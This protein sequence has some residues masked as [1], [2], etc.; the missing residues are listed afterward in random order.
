[1]NI[2]FYK[3]SGGGSGPKIMAACLRVNNWDDYS[4]KTLFYLT[5]YDEQGIEH[6]IGS[7]K[8]G[9]VNQQH[10]WT[11][12]S[13]PPFFDFLPEKYFSLGQDVSYYESLQKNLTAELFEQVLIG[14]RD[15]AYDTNIF[16]IA[17]EER[18]FKDSLTRGVSVSAI[19]NQYRRVI[20]G[21]AVLTPFDFSY[22]RAATD[23]IGGAD[24]SFKVI[25]G[26]KPPTNMHVLIG[27]NG[28]GK[29]TLLNGMIRSIVQGAD[30]QSG[31]G[32]FTDN[33]PWSGGGPIGSDYFSSV[34][35]V[36]FSAFDPFIPPPDRIN[37]AEGTCYYYIGLK[38]SASIKPDGSY[39]LKTMVELSREF[40]KSLSVCFSLEKKR[41]QWVAAIKRLESDSNFKSMDLPAL[42]R[43]PAFSAF[44]RAE[45]LFNKMSSGHAIVLLTITRLVE[46]VEEKTLVLLDEPE[47]HLHPPLLSA[48]TRAMSDL[49]TDRNG[50]AIIAT[51]SPVV[52]QEVPS[53]CVWKVRRSNLMTYAERPESETFAENVGVLTREVFGL[54]V[55]K[56]GFYDLLAQSIAEGKGYQEVF[57]EYGGQLGFE[58]QALLRALIKAQE[59]DV[60]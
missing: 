22:M 59:D 44:N 48:F 19:N 35:S 32:V 20:A 15:I 23:L 24:L 43:E 1:M 21:G 51:H 13:L 28:V 46:T 5:V 7:V 10:G 53:S 49:L 58:G 54:E 14:L 52:L 4:F 6:D 25:P 11:E 37:K 29:T 34:A 17:K 3:H 26:S 41:S 27:R 12:E 9:Y 50:V 57:S 36:S 31:G 40:V 38:D 16:S 42:A 8:I 30:A 33:E 60:L 45:Y 47:S 39:S 2:N 56:S 55:A 18:V